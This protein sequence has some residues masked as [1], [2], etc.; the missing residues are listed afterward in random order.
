MTMESL[1]FCHYSRIAQLAEFCAAQS[2]HLC[3]HLL[4]MLAELRCR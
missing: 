2:H 4:G 3:Q 1:G